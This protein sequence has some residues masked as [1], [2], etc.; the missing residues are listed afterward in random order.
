MISD[1]NITRVEA[2][3]QKH[4]ANVVFESIVTIYKVEASRSD[5]EIENSTKMQPGKH[6]LQE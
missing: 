1:G 5:L 6:K 3:R 4:S 2:I